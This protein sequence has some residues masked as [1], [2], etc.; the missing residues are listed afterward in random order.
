VFWSGDLTWQERRVVEAQFRAAVRVVDVRAR[1]Y[2]LRNKPVGPLLELVDGDIT[3]PEGND[4]H[5]V[6]NVDVWDPR[7]T[8]NV[9][10]GHT[11]TGLWFN[12]QLQV[13]W[14]EWIPEWD[15]F[16]YLPIFRGD[17]F[18]T[19]RRDGPVITL[20][21]ADRSRQHR[22][23][24]VNKKVYK[25]KKHNRLFRVIKGLMESRGDRCDFATPSRRVRKAGSV[26]VG[27]DVWKW[28][29]RKTG[30]FDDDFQLY[31]LPNGRLRLRRLPEQ[32]VWVFNEGDDSMLTERPSE[33]ITMRDYADR[34]IV[35]GEK[36]VK[37][38]VTRDTELKEKCGA[39]ATT[40]KVQNADRFDDATKVRVGRGDSAKVRKVDGVAGDTITINQ[41]IG[42]AFAKGAKVRIWL[43]KERTRT[44]QEKQDLP[45]KHPF[46]AE[47]MS[48]GKRP[49]IRIIK[50]DHGNRK[51]LRNTAKRLI[52]REG[53]V[54]QE[55]EITFRPIPN[56]EKGDMVRT[57]TVV[58]NRSFR[59]RNMHLS[60]GPEARQTANYKK[61]REPRRSRR[62]HKKGRKR[63]RGRAGGIRRPR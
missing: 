29:M 53:K 26:G 23:P 61:G 18:P 63:S 11:K 24:Y 39:G 50:K 42:R 34:I 45:A 52:K 38:T 21:A 35:K 19:V 47:T 40:I 3:W 32:A 58:F 31:Y 49:A 15:R 46:S 43:E 54:E 60:L 1:L 56:L 36:Q 7:R 44:L 4:A 17:L 6:A 25:W 10:L 30:E 12:K 57:Q 2:D 5:A 33:S 14:G 37:D 16:Y 62:R 59:V 48:L 9:D 20:V 27:A 8:L 51:R 13:W 28:A 22:P 41:A 55:S